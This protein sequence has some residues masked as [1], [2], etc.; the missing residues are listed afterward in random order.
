MMLYKPN[1]TV[2]GSYTAICFSP[3]WIT[4]VHTLNAV[5]L[6]SFFFFFFLMVGF[7]RGKIY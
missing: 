3:W 6:I 1:E 4:G 2:L 7:K 5:P